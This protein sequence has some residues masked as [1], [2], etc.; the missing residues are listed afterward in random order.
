[1]DPVNL[2]ELFKLCASGCIR[3]NNTN[4]A[5]ILDVGTRLS[6]LRDEGRT[7]CLA[8]KWMLYMDPESLEFFKSQFP[9]EVDLLYSRCK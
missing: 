5:C 3:D 9:K 8:L 2:K 4:R 1:M 6:I 7:N